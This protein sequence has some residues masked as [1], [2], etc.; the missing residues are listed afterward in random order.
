M[1]HKSLHNA[2]LRPETYPEPT[3]SVSFLETHISRLYITDQHVYKVKKPVDFGFLNFSTLNRRKFYCQEELRLNRRFAPGIYLDV[4]KI[5][6]RMGK[7]TV[8][9]DGEPIEYTLRMKRLPEHRML[10][11]LI[12]ERDPTLPTEMLRLARRIERLHAESSPCIGPEGSDLE[13]IRRNWQENYSQVVPFADSLYPR[14]AF[15]LSRN[16]TE[17]FLESMAPLIR[18][19]EIHGHVRDVHGDLH[20]EHICLSDPVLIFDCI[21]FNRRFRISDV[22]NDLAFLLMDLDF[23]GRSDLGEILLREYLETANQGNEF[24]T[25]VPFYKTYR[26]FV[27]GKVNAFLAEELP[28]GSTEETE[29]THK[30]RRYFGL[31]LGYL[32]PPLLILTCGLMGVGKTTVARNLAHSTRGVLIRSDVLRKELVGMAPEEGME[33]L[34][35][36]G[37]YAPNLTKQTYSLLLA[38]TLEHLNRGSSVIADASFA[39]KADRELFRKAANSAGF[40]VVLIHM[41]CDKESSLRRLSKRREVG[42]DASDGRPEL[43]DQ[44]S[45]IFEAPSDEETPFQV[46]TTGNVDYNTLL[47]LCHILDRLGTRP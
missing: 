40:P 23:R 17:G 21:E 5:C 44:Q 14:A 42:L 12:E 31:A 33:N 24:E 47:V 13:N 36:E 11:H 20:V 22:A 6:S 34:Y 9:T 25:L 7:I 32:T 27:R 4:L 39:R 38:K 43:Y 19:R 16:I 46:D 10:S 18:D 26:A 45:R 2:L 41:T 30:A 35:G 28:K 1:T 3:R 8:G 29:A 37:I 15:D